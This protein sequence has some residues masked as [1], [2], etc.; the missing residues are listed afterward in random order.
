MQAEVAFDRRNL[1]RR[2]SGGPKRLD[3]RQLAFQPTAIFKTS[4]SDPLTQTSTSVG[5]HTLRVF[6]IFS[7]GVAWGVFVS[8]EDA[9]VLL[10]IPVV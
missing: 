3:R 9:V 2:V 10:G 8:L 7:T 1:H 5:E 6:R 4:S